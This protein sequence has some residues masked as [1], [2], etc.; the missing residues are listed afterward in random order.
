M[1][2]TYINNI[3]MWCLENSYKDVITINSTEVN[4]TIEVDSEGRYNAILFLG[5]THEGGIVLAHY[6]IGEL[7]QNS[8]SVNSTIKNKGKYSEVW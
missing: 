7:T 1:L 4:N 2:A 8:L 6:T 3:A 5:A